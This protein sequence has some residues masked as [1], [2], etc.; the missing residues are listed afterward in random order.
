MG[1]K[2]SYWS[3]LKRGEAISEVRG[4]VKGADRAEQL[5]ALSTRLDAI[6]SRYR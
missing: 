3:N 5:E 6:A 2:F 1:I 4:L